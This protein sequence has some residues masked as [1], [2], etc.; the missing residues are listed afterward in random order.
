M[1]LLRIVGNL[2]N[3]T[4]NKINDLKLLGFFVV[5][6]EA[7]N[8]ETLKLKD[9]VTTFGVD[10]A[11]IKQMLSQL[12]QLGIIS[13]TSSYIET[14]V[15]IDITLV[16][17]QIIINS[18]EDEEHILT[19]L[20]AINADTIKQI[21]DI[22]KINNQI[23]ED[24]LKRN[25]TT[26]LNRRDFKYHQNSYEL[27]TIEDVINYFNE[28]Y[29]H[30]IFEE[31]SV[32][33]ATKDLILIYELHS[34]Y[35]FSKQLIN[36]LVDFTLKTTEYGNFNH[37]FVKRVAADWKKNHITTASAAFNRISE[38]KNKSSAFK[39]GYLEPEFIES[40]LDS[41]EEFNLEELIN[42]AYNK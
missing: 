40:N 39:T 34:E 37:N 41:S 24:V 27:N 22:S 19:A 14:N 13:Y 28:I 32:Y 23:N 25:I 42:D 30:E 10:E 26:L 8:K 38:F 36:T 21:E 12:K 31:S 1:V 2:E 20:F 11:E 15:I 29:P 5:L 18:K 16:N 33:V 4:I 7:A 6:Q 3:Y 9:I 35:G 17:E